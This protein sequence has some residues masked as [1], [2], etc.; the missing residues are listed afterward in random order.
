MVHIRTGEWG[1]K[2]PPFY[3]YFKNVHLTLVKKSAAKFC[4]KSRFFREN[5]KIGFLGKIS[6]ECTFYLGQIY[7]F[8]VSIKRRIFL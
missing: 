8:E 3:I 2:N 7:I 5:G 4:P 6:F 1:I